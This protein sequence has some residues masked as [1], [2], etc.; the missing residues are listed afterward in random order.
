MSPIHFKLLGREFFLQYPIPRH[1]KCLTDSNYISIIKVSKDITEI[2]IGDIH[3]ILSTTGALY[4]KSAKKDG[5]VQRESE[6]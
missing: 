4:P 6:H 1:R 2:F 5:Q 3:V